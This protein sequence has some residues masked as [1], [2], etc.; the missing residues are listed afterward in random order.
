MFNNSIT[1]KIAN[2]VARFKP[3]NQPL[4]ELP[5]PFAPRNSDSPSVWDIT[6]KICDRHHILHLC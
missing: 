2:F 4:R 3:S 5:L 1:P 6:N